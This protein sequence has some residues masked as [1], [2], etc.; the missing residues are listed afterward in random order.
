MCTKFWPDTY[1]QCLAPKVT[2]LKR[3]KRTAFARTVLQRCNVCIWGMHKGPRG[4]QG[5]RFLSWYGAYLL[6]GNGKRVFLA[7]RCRDRS[8]LQLPRGP[9]KAQ[10]VHRPWTCMCA[11]RDLPACTLIK[12]WA[13]GAWGAVIWDM[14]CTSSAEGL[15]CT[16][17]KR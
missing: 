4:T 11:Q 16:Q 10:R 8:L 12:A 2:G 14:D 5:A 1:W 7:R 3:P 6:Q 13:C 17:P 15:Y 9:R